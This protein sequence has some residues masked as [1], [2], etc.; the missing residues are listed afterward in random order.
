MSVQ[1]VQSRGIYH[2][3]PVFP[4]N[5]KGLKAIV[6]GANG[7]S[8]QHMVRVLAE[9]PER[10]SKIYCLSRRPPAI[11]GGVPSNAEHI[12]LDFLKSPEE[13]GKVLKDHGVEAY[14]HLYEPIGARADRHSDYVFFYS[15]IQVAPK[16]GAA[17][18]SNAQEMADTN[19]KIWK[20]FAL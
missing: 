2:G 3:L 14:V 9:A 20:S 19:S 15:Y 13:I 4:D 11:P 6:T 12:P 16:E 18:W 8:G 10:W 5:L 17:L 1:Q 7:I